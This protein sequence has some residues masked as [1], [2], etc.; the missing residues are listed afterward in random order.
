MMCGMHYIMLS[1]NG[2][3]ESLCHI[4]HN[5]YILFCAHNIASIAVSYDIKRNICMILRANNI[6]IIFIYITFNIKLIVYT[7]LYAYE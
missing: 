3:E 2:P 4:K 1:R 6:D 7:I 5:I